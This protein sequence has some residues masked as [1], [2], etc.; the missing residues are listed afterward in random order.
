MNPNSAWTAV[1]ACTATGPITVY[2][3]N[4]TDGS[5]VQTVDGEASIVVGRP[6]PRT[7]AILRPYRGKLGRKAA[8]SLAR[9]R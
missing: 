3:I 9:Q 8:R 4:R 6:V 1:S 7:P 2:V 5:T